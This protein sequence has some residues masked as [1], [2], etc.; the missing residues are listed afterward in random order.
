MFEHTFQADC[1]QSP[2]GVAFR[3]TRKNSV[4]QICIAEAD[5]WPC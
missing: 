5:N 3:F 1:L 2:E 4:M